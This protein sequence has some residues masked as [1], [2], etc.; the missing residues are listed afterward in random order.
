[1]SHQLRAL[2]LN[3]DAESLASLKD[4]LPGWAVETAVKS[5]RPGDA[6]PDRGPID[7]LV[8]GVQDDTG[9]VT[10]VCRSLRRSPSVEGVP[11]VVLVKSAQD[12]LVTE[13]LDAGADR[14]LVVPIDPK[15]I[16]DA[17][18]TARNGNRPGRHTLGLAQAQQGDPWRDDGGQ[19]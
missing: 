8:V 14:C 12:G 3:V 5:L 11:L 7:L 16:V 2:A 10:E 1:M 19:G 9:S 4:A 6:L 17:L 13:V 18:A 15:Q